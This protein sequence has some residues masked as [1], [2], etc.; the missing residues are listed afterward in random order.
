MKLK[1]K[2]SGFTIAELLITLGIIGIVAAITLPTLIQN[3]KNKEVETKLRKIYS[4]MNQAILISEK[5]N[6]PKEYWSYCDFGELTNMENPSECKQH[7]DKYILPYIKYAKTEEFTTAGRYN[8]AIYFSDG[9]VLIGKMHPNLVDYYYYPNG[10]NFK[11]DEFIKVNDDGTHVR[12][13]CG[14]TFFAFEFS[15][16]L[17][18]TNSKFH[19]RKAFEPYKRDIKEL[20]VEE[21]TGNNQYACK[22]NA[23]Y[24]LWC[25]ALIQL[26]GWKIPKDYPFKVK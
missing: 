6:G 26:N 5:D 23:N 9:S 21:L 8:I 25:T 12:E 1:V 22:K 19:Y 3:N 7:F 16:I 14:T 10:K 18:D 2:I 20:T 13:M 15:P 11:K 17:N 24:K 4:I